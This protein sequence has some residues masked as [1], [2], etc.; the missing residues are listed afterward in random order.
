MPQRTGNPHPHAAPGHLRV[1]LQIKTA[2][3]LTCVVSAVVA[4]GAWSYY[5]AVYDMMRQKDF[6]HAVHLGKAFG[7]AVESDLRD[8]ND[9]NL[10]RLVRDWVKENVVYVAIVDKHG[11]V[12]ACYGELRTWHTRIDTKPETLQHTYYGEGHI[13][14]A[15]PVIAR[16]KVWMH[17][18]L[19]GG[20]RA[21][22]DARQTSRAL[23]DARRRII[24]TAGG[25]ELIA[26][27]L[28]YLWIWRV[29][30]RPFRRLTHVT[31]RLAD[32]DF[33]VR[34]D[35]KR[36]DEAGELGSA[37]DHMATQVA[38]MRFQLLRQHDQLEQT[39]KKRTREL[40]QVNE[41]LCDEMRDKEEFLRA[42]SHDLN[43]PMRNIAGMATMIMMNHR[44]ELPEDA[45]SRLQR[46]QSNVDQQSALIDELLEISRIKS[47][48]DAPTQTNVAQL[49][50]ELADTF[51]YELQK[52]N[53]TLTIDEPMPVFWV[54]KRRLRQAFQNL[55]DNAVKYMHR[56]KDGKIEVRYRFDGMKH[57]FVVWDNGPG[58]PPDQREKIFTV[59]RR[60]YH[61]A[62]TKIEGKG[63]GLTVVRTI[64]SKYGGR[65]WV[66]SSPETGT[67]FHISLSADCVQCP[68]QEV[69]H[70]S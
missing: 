41:R 55:L 5:R 28:A 59:F 57:E 4:L 34:A 40:Q 67:S 31:R 58:I 17:E 16:D 44:D 15:R 47:R 29:V 8:G 35:M 51:E 60:G 36:N 39:V 69:T 18:R 3:I 49:L 68:E 37:F 50:H 21:V 24:I 42:V 27:P 19:A 53:I 65:A 43:A 66:E 9:Q 70:V 61:P 6:D 46:I 56:E 54:D 45:L 7:V 26:L 38:S 48:P 32:G 20:V 25:I 62:G 52:R 13:L 22:L 14:I 64:A 12:A 23:L 33:N 30:L 11:D 2:L 1:G 63:V 10:R